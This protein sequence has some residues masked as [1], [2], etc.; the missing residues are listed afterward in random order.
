[1]RC[2][3]IETPVK[4]PLGRVLSFRF[5]SFLVRHLIGLPFVDTQCG[6]KILPGRAYRAVAGTLKEKGFIFDVELLLAL[7]R[8]GSQIKEVAIPWREIP[9]GK[10]HPLR[11]AWRMAGGLFRINKRLRAGH[12]E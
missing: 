9:G 11:D 7:D 8:H 1:M 5:F 2:D 3:S 4:R 12:Y 10:V 6:V